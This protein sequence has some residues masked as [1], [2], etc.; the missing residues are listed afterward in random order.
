MAAGAGLRAEDAVVVSSLEREL[1]INFDCTAISRRISGS[2][3]PGLDTEAHRWRRCA[4]VAEE[5]GEVVQALLGVAGENPRKGVTH[6]TADLEAELLDVAVAALAAVS[7]LHHDRGPDL[8]SKLQVHA[9]RTR[10]RLEAAMV[11]S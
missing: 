6:T 2:Y 7:Y 11:H 10:E 5:A 9:R 8:V 1:A 4:K 3:P